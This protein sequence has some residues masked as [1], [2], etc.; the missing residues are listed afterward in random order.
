MF[1][2]IVKTMLLFVLMIPLTQS[3]AF[4]STQTTPQTVTT[5]TVVAQGLIYMKRVGHQHVIH[6]LT[7]DP[8]FYQLELVKAHNQVF[9][10]DVVPAIAKRR[11]AVAAINAGFFEIGGNQDG[12]PSGTLLI[13]D[14]LYELTKQTHSLL[15]IDHQQVSISRVR[16]VVKI[17]LPNGTQLENV[18]INRYVK[19]KEIVLYNHLWGRGSLTPHDRKEILLDQHAKVI[20][21]STHGDNIIPHKGW[22]LSLPK[23]Y[24]LS[25]IKI[26]QSI[27]INAYFE[28]AQTTQNQLL[29]P[30]NA[31]LGL[32]ILIQDGHINPEVLAAK[33]STLTL[34]H[35][36][37]AVGILPD[38]KII[39]VVVEHRYSQ[40]LRKV[41][42]EQVQDILIRHGYSK[43]RIALMTAFEMRAIVEKELT[44]Q[45]NTIGLSLKELAQF[46]A[47]LGARSAINLDGG[48]SATMVV[49]NTVVNQTIGDE[50]EANAIEA[51]RP[52][53][54]A[55][56]VIPAIL[57]RA[58][59]SRT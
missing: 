8:R 12:Q 33:K 20:D 32:P 30:S 17:T 1:N 16:G 39:L 10:R 42:L 36:H 29:H 50:D 11:G 2:K 48:G 18:R 24:K 31:V 57:S 40:P 41:T 19:G 51:L 44:R 47:D 22:I 4:S 34:P 5:K 35:A 56:V 59:H 46:M 58:H 28:N 27:Q 49:N 45:S 6:V 52:V 25:K 21:I 53:S 55:L 38:Q 7:I 54:D 13:H 43:T 9:G 3:T 23:Q 26:D 15:M 14:H 37:T